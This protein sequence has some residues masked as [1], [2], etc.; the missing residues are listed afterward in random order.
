MN[1]HTSIISSASNLGKGLS[2]VVL[3]HENQRHA[4]TGGVSRNNRDC[5]FVPAFQDARTGRT[6]RSCFSD[7]RPA[8]MHLLEGLPG[9]L[10]E[11][12][13]DQLRARSGVV[14]GFLHRGEFLTRA[15]A[16][17]ALKGRLSS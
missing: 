10:L 11:G 9:H 5:G 1:N 8:P 17:A 4:G 7:G 14:S 15:E 12:S 6:Y 16:A 13:S 3:R 2:P